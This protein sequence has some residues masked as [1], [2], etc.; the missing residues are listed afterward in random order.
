M[1]TYRGHIL[2]P[3]KSGGW[4]DIPDGTLEE[5]DG[6]IA[7]VGRS[8]KHDIDLRPCLIIPGFV[9]THTHVPQ[10]SV[11]GVHP[12]GLLP[13]LRKWVYPIEAEFQGGR[14]IEL[15]R[16]FFQ[17]MVANGTTAAALYTSAWPESVDACF[18]A[19]RD[20]GVHAWIGPPLMDIGAYRRARVLEEAEDLARKWDSKTRRFAVTPRFALSCSQDLLEGAGDLARRLSL[21]V[22][23]HLNENPDEVREVRHRFHKPYVDVYEETGLGGELSLFAHCVHMSSR[24]WKKVRR[25]AHCPTANLFLHSGVMDW[26]AARRSGA[27]LS[28][29]SDVGAGPDLSLYFVMRSAWEMHALRANQGPGPEDLLRMATLGGAEALGFDDIGSLEPGMSADFQVLDWNS[30]VP[31]GAPPA[32]SAHDLVSR[33]V[34][35]GNRAAIRR[36]YVAGKQVIDRSG[37]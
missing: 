26:S 35:R 5:R 9:D 18:E 30:I 36:I 34:H 7:A 10:L 23:T 15:T 22:Q 16:R 3:R 1:T 11:C 4:A 19:A 24:D 31:A 32:E 8:R 2:T 6:V 21:P 28:L 27:T 33:I 25:V 13:W 37:T 17:E 20:M 29:G 12:E 14:A